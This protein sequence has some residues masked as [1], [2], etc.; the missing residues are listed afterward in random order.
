MACNKTAIIKDIEKRI[1]RTLKAKNTGMSNDEIRAVAKAD[2]PKMFREMQEEQMGDAADAKELSKPEIQKLNAARPHVKHTN[3]NTY[4]PVTVV[5]RAS[6][7]KINYT[8]PNGDK[9]YP[10][11][12]DKV[13]LKA[14]PH[15]TAA[16]QIVDTIPLYSISTAAANGAS[17]DTN[18]DRT[19][20]IS[21]AVTEARARYTAD[22]STDNANHL[23]N[24]EALNGL[25]NSFGKTIAKGVSPRKLQSAKDAGTKDEIEDFYFDEDGSM[26]KSENINAA[27][28]EWDKKKYGEN[29]DVEHSKE[30]GA[31]LEAMVNAIEDLNKADVSITEAQLSSRAAKGEYSPFDNT[32]EIHV[33]SR[34][35]GEFFRQRFTQTAQEVYVHELVHAATEFIFDGSREVQR[36]PTIAGMVASVKELY[37]SARKGL[38]SYEGLLPGYT[39]GSTT[40]S[41]YEVAQAK[42][43]YDYIFNNK[44]GVGLEEFMSHL[45]TNKQFRLAMSNIDAI[46]KATKDEDAGLIDKII[47]GFKDF[48]G[49]LVGFT[50]H[51]KNAS[52]TEA[53]TDLLFKV[54][55]AHSDNAMKVAS[56]HPAR[57]AERATE[58]LDGVLNKS[59]EKLAGVADTVISTAMFEGTASKV[60]Y[61][62]QLAEDVQ[63][64]KDSKV[65]DPKEVE[66]IKKAN[67]EKIAEKEKLFNDIGKLLGKVPD[68]NSKE[69]RSL[70]GKYIGLGITAAGMLKDLF[71]YARMLNKLRK[72]KE[73]DPK[74]YAQRMAKLDG[75]I[76]RVEKNVIAKILKDFS[77]K[78]LTYSTMTDAILKLTHDVDAMR[79]S[80]YED[81]LGASKEWFGRIEVNGEA[82]R[83][84]NDA[85]SDTILR[86]D[87]QSL[88]VDSKGLLEL[89]EDSGKVYSEIKALAKVIKDKGMLEDAL[90]AAEAMASG[91]GL[92]TNPTNIASG[93]G[94]A[95]QSPDP[96]I[97][98]A[99]DRYI[100]LKALELTSSEVKKTAA[101]FI[102]GRD[103]KRISESKLSKAGKKLKLIKGKEPMTQ[104]EYTAQVQEGVN[105][106]LQHSEGTDARSKEEMTGEEH[107]LIKGYMKESFDTGNELVIVPLRERVDLE[108]EGYKYVRD[109]KEHREGAEPYAIFTR[110]D[111]KTSRANGAIGLQGV[112]A[113][114]VSLSAMIHEEIENAPLGE[115]IDYFQETAKFKKELAMQVKE[116]NR[117]RLGADMQPVYNSNGDIVDFRTNMTHTEKKEL[118]DMETRGTQNLARTYGTFGTAKATEEHNKKV[119]QN[120]KNDADKFASSLPGDYVTIRPRAALGKEDFGLE[121]VVPKDAT[122]E[123]QLWARLPASTKKAAADLYDGEN[124]IIIRRDLVLPAFGENDLSVSDSPFGR[125]FS[126]AGRRNIKQIENYWQDLM[127]IAKGNIV[128]K[129]PAVLIG[130]VV[131]NAKIL[132]YLGVNPIK[133]TKLLF[134]GARELKRYESDN[135]ELQ[136][137]KRVEGLSRTSKSNSI[138]IEELEASLKHNMVRP[139]IDA[140]M[141]QSI[142][143]DVSTRK[144]TNRVSERANKL[145][146][147]YVTNKGANTAVQYLFLTEKTKPFQAMLKATQVSDFY[148]RFAQ[149]YDTIDKLEAQA[150]SANAGNKNDEKR[151]RVTLADY[152]YDGIPFKTR[153]GN[154]SEELMDAIKWH[155]MREITDNYINYEAPLNDKVR[156]WDKM[157]PGFV[158]YYTNIQRVIKKIAKKSPG[159][160][161]SD[162]ALQLVIGDTDGIEDQTFIEKGLNPYTFKTLGMIKEAIIPPGPEVI[163]AYAR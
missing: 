148:F 73:I 8:Y 26:S 94:R 162:F 61:Y 47:N 96:K 66:K 21:K 105:S 29:F 75:F 17:K 74:G 102:S 16:S 23:A 43:K 70:V 72:L 15:D 62:K 85:L 110:R 151:L 1:A 129:V 135:K 63:R 161:A 69:Y 152:I 25:R 119:L 90:L 54:M 32:I 78:D 87:I 126:K 92:I 112:K 154:V 30:L 12:T 60:E 145:V 64:V 4:V 132:F 67:E 103:Y 116:Y 65:T 40:Y 42:E 11:A 131:S 50:T 122:Q 113:R 109:V 128:I 14:G 34:H 83:K 115:K 146:D 10:I 77:T 142:V 48:L 97:V 118:L 41:E 13:L 19:V 24:V 44:E 149:Y 38:T 7:G 56:K 57:V 36:D 98:K 53:G 81:V 137:L 120:I 157:N 156:Y 49:R 22:P 158:R 108:K 82:F 100:S 141:Y 31:T 160:V 107:N 45:L 52:I 121:G 99:L 58:Y 150:E 80:N 101:D 76:K 33:D 163:M 2:A 124:K 6:D 133:G 55:K 111:G 155:S 140:G 68:R 159:R 9:A 27:L 144:E 93:F 88:G 91:G 134:L 3:G 143:E 5:G 28:T 89:L 95:I 114:G 51:K 46:S 106:F 71:I 123:E 136:E 59:D 147:K 153:R 117:D 139:L 86:T 79:E 37:S 127:Q 104:D 35:N 20:T 125:F 138:R 18:S 130:N 84:Q 39:D